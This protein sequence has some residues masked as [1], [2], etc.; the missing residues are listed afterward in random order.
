[1]AQR[2]VYN[3]AMNAYF[4]KSET[5]EEMPSEPSSKPQRP[6]SR[7]R[8]PRLLHPSIARTIAEGSGDLS[9]SLSP[10][11]RSESPAFA[12]PRLQPHTPAVVKPVAAQIAPGAPRKPE[13]E[14]LQES[15]GYR[16]KKAR[17]AS[18]ARGGHAEMDV[19]PHSSTAPRKH[20]KSYASS[21]YSRFQKTPRI[22]EDARR[23]KDGSRMTEE[24]LKLYEVAHRLQHEDKKHNE[25][26]RH[27]EGEPG[28]EGEVRY[29]FPDD[30]YVELAR[31]KQQER[32]NRVKQTNKEEEDRKMRKRAKRE[33][34]RREEEQFNQS[35]GEP[36]DR[37]VIITKAV[38]NTDMIA[39]MMRKSFGYSADQIRDGIATIQSSV[40]SP[41]A[42]HAGNEFEAHLD[43]VGA[44]ILTRLG[45]GINPDTSMHLEG[46]T[47]DLVKRQLESASE[48]AKSFAN[49]DER[50]GVRLGDPAYHYRHMI[51]SIV[52]SAFLAKGKMTGP[53][54]EA[55]LARLQGGKK[56]KK[57]E[58]DD[59]KMKSQE[60]KESLKDSMTRKSLL[61]I[62]KSG[63]PHRKCPK[64]KADVKDG[65]TKCSKCGATVRGNVK[66]TFAEG[67][68]S[69]EAKKPAAKK[70]VVSDPIST[71][72]GGDR[73]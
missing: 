71:K 40:A 44:L 56:K 6:R 57:P 35:Y 27:Y 62:Y 66:K 61:D 12:A 42:W 51:D 24:E 68:E 25:L 10:L 59:E 16:D 30:R 13:Q 8:S 58:D 28:G 72:Y 5:G 46:S 49:R 11:R 36:E 20:A 41:G 50:N 23:N 63:D 38:A 14:N 55:L 4:A 33:M 34:K 60:K 73:G 45:A 18:A 65:E 37:G 70:R 32:E 7:S 47:A 21:Y 9:R 26:L 22:P 43:P 17:R 39:D 53:E 29:E 19:P 69:A 3:S 31:Q 15:F 1:M 67:A 2:Y 52:K 54:K 48:M 64:C